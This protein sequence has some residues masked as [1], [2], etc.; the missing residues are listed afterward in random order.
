MSEP[1]FPSTAES[2][3]PF[4][5]VLGASAGGLEAL[6]R[7]FAHC[8]PDTGAAFVV[9]QHL[10]PDHKSIMHELLARHTGMKVR[11][12]EHGLPIEP[13]QVFLIPPGAVMR[14]RAGCFELTPKTPHVLTLPIDIFL[15][16]L[17]E[18]AGTRGV[19]VVLSG[20]GS[21]G[22]RGAVALNAAGGFLLA[23]A[24]TDARFDGMPSSVI[25]T[26]LVDDV[27][28]ADELAPRL[29]A[30]LRGL[31]PPLAPPPSAEDLQPLEGDAARE[32]IVRLLFQAGGIDFGDY[33]PAT[34]MR[35]IE[36]R[37]Q[38][39]HARSLGNYVALLSQDRQELTALR[40][41]LLIPVTSFF[42]DAET[43]DAVARL[44]VD[45]LVAG[46]PAGA[47]LRVWVAG[48]S[49]GEEAYSLAMVFLEACERQQRWP[50]LKVFAT[51]VN[52]QNIE[53]AAQ[54]RYPE[55]A[56]AELTP[57][58]L[59]RFFTRSGSQIVVTP[60]LRQR[61]VFARHNLL[62]DPPFTRMGLVSCRN[63]LIYFTTDAQRRAL[64][65]MQYALQPEGFLFLG[66][67][68]SV[69]GMASTLRP[70]DAKYKLFRRGSGSL[71]PSLG[72]PGVGG[73][74]APRPVST[75][76]VRQAVARPGQDSAGID[77]ATALLMGRYAPPSMLVNE[78]H[79]VVHLFGQVQ[80]YFQP[81]G[82]SPSFELS[83]VLPP[84]LVPVA[85][86]LLYGAAREGTPMVSDPMVLDTD[87]RDGK[88]GPGRAAVR[89]SVRPLAPRGDTRLLLLS[90]EPQQAP[91]TPVDAAPVDVGAETVERIEVL[92][93]ELAATRLSLQAT[94]E[95]LET[96]NEELQATNEE[97]MASNEELQS[98]NEELQSVN[99]EL[100]TVNA[101]YQEKL[102]VVSR[103][104]ADLDSMARAVGVA[105]VFVDQH[106]V[107]TRYSPDAVGIFK[108]R[109][110][111]IGRPLDEIVHTLDCP[112]LIADLRRTVLTELPMEKQALGRDGRRYV[113][114]ILPCRVSSSTAAGAVATF[115]DITDVHQ[116][117]RLQTIID[118]L[119]E[120]LAVLAPDGRIVMINRAWRRFAQANGD[121]TLA[122]CGIGSDYLAVCRSD[123]ASTDG[124]LA[125]Q[126][127]RGVRAVLEGSRDSYS[128]HYPCHSPTEERWFIMNVAPLPAEVLGEG[129]A[130]GA[131]VSHI[132]IT[133]WRRA[134]Q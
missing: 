123:A 35:R 5:V 31:P 91:S 62:A 20:T 39:R 11:L 56:A 85:A 83:R 80:P 74:Y 124:D 8:P 102:T 70:V 4:V 126:A 51:D 54:G 9:I 67:S 78:R 130:G 25:A 107:L 119:P 103:L 117:R 65:R 76:A 94:I 27:L 52:P 109:E 79:E 82:G 129:G 77:E 57:Q 64:Q 101:E 105:T 88:E 34:M 12:V 104:N 116:H 86:A 97:L 84:R 66:P 55:S 10:S 133:A 69:L 50:A 63:T 114:R 40:R 21:D 2:A 30:H 33:K 45:E 75:A 42:R 87:G 111:D 16:S 44:A 81:R 125:A 96:S 134:A 106:M 118:A 6:E 122:A 93:R 3:L 18:D 14:I 98:S 17:A 28:P 43:F 15:N 110:G 24:P 36:R 72:A 121:P 73:P 100:N 22:T 90:F 132:D 7:F 115:V 61:I 92:Q 89:L 128:L 71:L 48:C 95:E 49:T 46:V 1:D 38:V 26:G 112:D 19:A 113:V 127:A 60:E 29:V 37:L 131:V 108:L 59:E 32:A 53:F 99:E 120:H 23:Q 13:D 47:A 58:R 41:E 68:E